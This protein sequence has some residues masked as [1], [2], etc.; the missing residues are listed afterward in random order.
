M[1]T[2]MFS[3]LIVKHCLNIEVR[4]EMLYSFFFGGGEGEGSIFWGFFGELWG[5]FM[6][7][8][9]GEEVLVGVWQGYLLSFIEKDICF[10]I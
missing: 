1:F 6:W 10:T 2:S 8:Y 3:S 5:I 4:I 9:F 7:G